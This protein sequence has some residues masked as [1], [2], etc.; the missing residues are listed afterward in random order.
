MVGKRPLKRLLLVEDDP[1]QSQAVRD[2]LELYG[3]AVACA[4]DG[5]TA[6]RM[7]RV[8]S[9]DGILLDLN[10]PDIP[11]MHVLTAA[12]EAMPDVPVLIMSASQSRLRAAKD[13]GVA[14]GY[15]AKPFGIVQFKLALQACFG[16]ACQPAI[17]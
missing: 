12:H 16:P 14:A 4:E 3:Y 11:G 8:G 9:F 6:L 17:S 1:D 15:I 10:L 13:S 2:R 7:L 5:Q